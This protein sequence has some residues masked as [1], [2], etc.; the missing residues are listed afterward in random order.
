[1]G[2]AAGFW[3]YTRRFGR[4]K[5]ILIVVSV[6]LSIALIFGV[7]ISKGGDA[8]MGQEGETQGPAHI[9]IS[10]DQLFAG[11]RTDNIELVRKELLKGVDINGANDSQQTALHVTQDFEIAV[12]LIDQGAD[13]HALDDM[14]MTPIFNKDVLI[15]QLLLDAGA[16]INAVSKKGNT[17]FIWYA[18]S[19][20]LEGLKWLV[21]N[22][23]DTN[24]CNQDGQ[25]ALDIAN[26]FHSG[27]DLQKYLQDQG[28]T[29]CL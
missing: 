16:D 9:D 11:I 13:I 21:F 2:V 12:L 28:L 29:Q 27:S 4:I 3:V 25:N 18:Y 6:V 1:M 23:A 8:L 7:F 10:T 26:L 5:I 17:L 14:L 19:G 15:A 24:R 20:Y 22:R